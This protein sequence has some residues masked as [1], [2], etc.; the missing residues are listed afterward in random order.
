M[1]GFKV[2][3][4]EWLLIQQDVKRHIT[5]E[6]KHWETVCYQHYLHYGKSVKEEVKG[7]AVAELP[8]EPPLPEPELV[9][10]E[11]TSM[12]EIAREFDRAKQL[13][14]EKISL[15]DRTLALVRFWGLES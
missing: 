10:Q 3:W 8:P 7:E 12:D 6:M 11:T 5:Q 9:Q 1:H 15:A 4:G 13:A 14:E 2:L